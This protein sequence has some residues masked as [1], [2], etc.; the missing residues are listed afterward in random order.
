VSSR[1]R[2]RTKH[3]SIA[4]TRSRLFAWNNLCAHL[5][6]LRCWGWNPGPDEC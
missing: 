3:R 6:F 4:D 5:I 2:V 1:P